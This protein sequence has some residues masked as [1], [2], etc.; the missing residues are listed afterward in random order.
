MSEELS[1]DGPPSARTDDSDWTN[2]YDDMASEGPLPKEDGQGEWFDNSF[3][4]QSTLQFYGDGPDPLDGYGL[5]NSDDDFLGGG[6]GSTTTSDTGNEEKDGIRGSSTSSSESSDISPKISDDGIYRHWCK[7]LIFGGGVAAGYAVNQFVLMG[8]SWNEVCVIS[9]E[10]YYPYERPNM[11]PLMMRMDRP[12]YA[13]GL[14]CCG[15]EKKIIM[16]PVI[17]T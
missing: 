5:S 4:K 8:A 14:Y 3:C 17:L 16:H 15:A 2:M 12:I 9:R 6:G 13:P 10:Q 1:C 11:I 7:T